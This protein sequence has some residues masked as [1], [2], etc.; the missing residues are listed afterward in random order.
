MLGHRGAYQESEEKLRCPERLRLT[1]SQPHQVSS[2]WYAQQLPVLQGF[3]T[4]MGFAGLHNSLA[5]TF[6]TR[7]NDESAGDDVFY[8]HVAIYSRG[9]SSNTD[10]ERA[11]ISA[12]AVHDLADGKVHIVKIRYYT[13]LQMTRYNYVPYFSATTNL[14]KFIKDVSDG[15]RV[16]TLVVF[17]DEGIKT[18][19]PILT[20]PINLSA[21]LRLDSDEAFV[22]FTTS[23]SS[24][25]QKHD[26]LGWFYCSEPPCLDQY[27]TE[28]TFDFDYNEQSMLSTA[29]HGNTLYPIFIYP[30]TAS[31]AK[32]QVYFSAN[33]KVGL[34]S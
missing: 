24:S 25:W 21:T 20:V 9:Q 12:A 16:G 10:S 7:L 22:G 19:T 31:W 15:R 11:G 3:E 29:S 26:V 34:V 23:T 2:I 5:I 14:P 1:A 13:E 18:D 30:D 27:D 4:R 6:E 33:Q 8:D 28:L 17:M 32:T